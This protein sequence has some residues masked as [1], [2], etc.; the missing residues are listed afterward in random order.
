[1]AVPSG[2][3]MN[4]Q[5]DQI[6]RCPFCATSFRV[7][8]EQLHTASG[9]VRCGACLRIFQAENSVIQETP[10][11]AGD[12]TP[13]SAEVVE[14]HA[15]SEE[16]S[17]TVSS[18]E[19]NEEENDEEN[20]EEI[21]PLHDESRYWLDWEFYV[22]GSLTQTP[23][24]EDPVLLEQFLDP[25]NLEWVAKAEPIS[26]AEATMNELVARLN[27]ERDPVELVGDYVEE[28]KQHPVWAILALL[29]ITSGFLQYVWFNR[30]YY[31][32]DDEYRP[33]YLAFCDRVGCRLPDYSNFSVISTSNLVVRSHPEF[34][35]A[36][37][38]DAIIRNSGTYRQK[39]PLLKL[40]FRDIEDSLVAIR[41]FNPRHYLAGEL[42]GLQ[43]IP[44]NTEVR[45][46]LELVHPGEHAVGF[47]LEIVE[48]RL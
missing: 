17:L 16:I 28:I 5:Q 33:L 21:V 42:R 43:Y 45:F 11:S 8:L 18:Y 23:G 6:T 39:F 40:Q 2:E 48:I 22:I 24:M 14:Q 25:D 13:A 38:V 1:M 29:L 3:E 44:A 47:S 7:T 46:S 4:N 36:L 35:D 10:E 26:E 12:L 9:T 20:N 37:I 32:Q 41:T 15:A 31:V 27:L 19:E 34:E 30:D